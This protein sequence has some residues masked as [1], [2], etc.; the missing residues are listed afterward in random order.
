MMTIL[1]CSERWTG[2]A[3]HPTVARNLYHRHGWPLLVWPPAENDN[4]RNPDSSGRVAR[5]P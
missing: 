2:L 5:R 4:G 3:P 1:R